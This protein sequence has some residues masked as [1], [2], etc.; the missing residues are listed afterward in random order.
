MLNNYHTHSLYCDGKDSI[1]DIAAEAVRRGFNQLGFSSHGPLPI[2]TDFAIKEE[3]MG[4][5]GIAIENAKQDHPDLMIFKALECD[6]IS[7]VSTPFHLFKTKYSLDYI[8]GGVHLV[9]PENCDKL[10]FIDGSLQKTYDDGL[11]QLF[12]GDAK[13]AV[14]R[15]WEQTF[16]MIETEEFDI[17]AHLDKIKMH[18]RNRYFAEDEDWYL[19]LV[20]HAIYSIK[21]KELIIEANTRGIYKGRCPD[22]YPSDYIIYHAAK[23]GVPF[24]ISSDA[25]QAVEL[26][27]HHRESEIKLKELGVK[28]LVSLRDGRWQ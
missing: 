2:E 1:A 24:V 13:K 17:I 8:I 28:H 27:L 19:K 3:D 6:F 23:M 9:I 12:G 4:E 10:W 11:Q 22:L 20:D 7:R 15:F 14:T 25:H 26:G 16:E 21:K 18:N 5:Y